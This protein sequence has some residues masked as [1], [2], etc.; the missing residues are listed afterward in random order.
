MTSET[1]RQSF[2][3]FFKNKGHIIVSS[4]P[5]IPENDPTTLFTGSGMQ[6]MLRYLLGEKHPLGRRIADAQKCFRAQDIDEVGDNRHTTFFE[7]LGNWS[8]GDFFKEEQIPW[9]F[10]FLTKEI[11]LNPRNIYV[12]VFR[13]NEKLKLPRDDESV[14]VWQ[15]VFAET[16]IEARTHDFAER[17]GMRDGRIFYYDETKNWWSRSGG[18]EQMPV[19]EPGGPDSEM[20]WDFGP[21][22]K[23]HENSEFQANPCHVNC[24]C[25]RF[26]EIGNNVFMEY[27]KTETGF[28]LL[29]QKNVDFGGGLERILAAKNNNPDVFE[30]DVFQSLVSKLK[31]LTPFYRGSTSIGATSI[32]ATSIGEGGAQKI[33]RIL[34]DHL[35]ASVFLIADGVRPS[36]KEAGYILR[37]LLRRIL[38]YRIKYDIHADLFP[39]AV[40]AVKEKFGKIYP[41]VTRTKEILTVLE[42]EKQKFEEAIGR[43]VKEIEKYKEIEGKEAFYLYETFG[44]PYE[45]VKELAPAE[46][47]RNLAKADFDKEFEKHQEISRAGAVKKFGGHGLILDTGELKAESE[48]KVGKAVQLHTATHLLHWALRETLGK[49][50]RQMGSDINPERSRFDFSFNRKLTPDEIQKIENLVNEKIE[51]DLPVNFEE[52]P[53]A[54]AEAVGALHFFKE[55]YPEKVK[56]YYIGT[57]LQNAMSKEFCG[58]PHVKKT[59]EIGK[60]K[61]IKEEAVGAGVRRIRLALAL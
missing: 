1:I 21:D 24:D 5:L 20:F 46:T 37:R 7:M 49:E 57:D 58:G 11:G 40:N 43:G 16:G 14:K 51:A 31:E 32:G 4:A 23:L 59:S 13:G 27:M 61:I 47:T 12:T 50:V 35:R 22:L 17:D 18:P 2:L 26:L 3:E 54:E 34:A 38:A 42:D 52:M 48:E 56:V 55:K 39:E 15:D 45:L 30:T 29:P 33:I 36:N 41:E 53:K 8:L 44:L 9:M 25:G 19:G 6:P 60:V 10:E 28:S